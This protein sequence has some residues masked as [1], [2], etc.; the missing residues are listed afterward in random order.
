MK[1]IN[2][3]TDIIRKFRESNFAISEEHQCKKEKIF[4]IIRQTNNGKLFFFFLI[5]SE[6]NLS[7]PSNENFLNISKNVNAKERLFPSLL[8]PTTESQLLNRT[9]ILIP[10]VIVEKVSLNHFMSKNKTLI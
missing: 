8:L 10:A 6:E 7:L 9:A 3:C 4:L 5:K 2:T 1:R